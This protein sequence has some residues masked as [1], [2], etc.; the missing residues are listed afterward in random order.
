MN[1]VSSI[2]G[3]ICVAV[4]DI[5]LWA[6]LIRAILSLF[7]DGGAIFNF[8]YSITEPIVIP[9]RKLLEKFNFA[10]AMPIDISSM[11]TYL[12]LSVLSTFLKVWF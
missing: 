11:I 5:I 8:V 1:E 6:M 12:L 10:S 2:L 9:V 4:V 3:L 7:T